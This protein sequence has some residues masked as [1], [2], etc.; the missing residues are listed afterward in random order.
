M[1]LSTHRRYSEGY[2]ERLNHQQ[3]LLA[4]SQT[5]L[6]N[7]RQLLAIAAVYVG[8]LDDC[9]TQADPWDR[10]RITIGIDDSIP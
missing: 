10:C 9:I 6:V 5:Q 7:D 1:M 2:P 4:S 8:R 3:L